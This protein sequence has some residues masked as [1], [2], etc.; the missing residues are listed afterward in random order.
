MFSS[1]SLITYHKFIGSM[2]F[3]HILIS[4]APS[5]SVTLDRHS[6]NYVGVIHDH[7][8][9]IVKATDLTSH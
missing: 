2:S 6:D 3:H 9:F 5:Y 1:T 7:Y 4:C 8:M